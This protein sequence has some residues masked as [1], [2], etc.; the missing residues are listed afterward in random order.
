[1]LPVPENVRNEFSTGTD[2]LLAG[3]AVRRVPEV[4]D[5]SREVLRLS[6]G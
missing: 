2:L 5:A 6:I 4:V 3:F 1:V